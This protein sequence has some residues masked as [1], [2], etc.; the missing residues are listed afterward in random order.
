MMMKWLK[1]ERY[2]ENVS[3][4][5]DF[6]RRRD[7]KV[8]KKWSILRSVGSK[9]EEEGK[10]SEQI[11]L[12]NYLYLRSVFLCNRESFFVAW[13]AT[14]V[15]GGG[16]GGYLAPSLYIRYNL[17]FHIITRFVVGGVAVVCMCV[18]SGSLPAI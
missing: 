12:F 9:E 10:G 1:D 11:K 8:L 15:P 16:G 2:L 6:I 14:K 7:K 17:P 18:L 13:K 5:R 3:K 4:K